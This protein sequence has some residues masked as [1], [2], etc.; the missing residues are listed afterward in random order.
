MFGTNQLSNSIKKVDSS[1]NFWKQKSP[2]YIGLEKETY[3]K[4]E[5]W[6]QLAS[7]TRV[8]VRFLIYPVSNRFFNH[9][10]T[11][12]IVHVF[13]KNKIPKSVRYWSCYPPSSDDSEA[14]WCQFHHSSIASFLKRNIRLKILFFHPFNRFISI[15]PKGKQFGLKVQIL[16]ALELSGKVDFLVVFK[17]IRTNHMAFSNLENISFSVAN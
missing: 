5:I 7:I 13:S 3:V 9:F 6:K 16:C 12:N 11:A 2:R 8:T 17:C 1:K 14:G 4:P 15:L 10:C